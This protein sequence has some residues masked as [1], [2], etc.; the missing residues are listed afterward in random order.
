MES[1]FIQYIGNK[2][3]KPDNVA[4]SNL[5]WKGHG[6][7]LEVSSVH[8]T[9]LLQH[10]TIWRDVTDQMKDGQAPSPS[11]N[12]AGVQFQG[13]RGEQILQAIKMMDET[14]S[15]HFDENGNPSIAV[16]ESTLQYEITP[17]E[18]GLVVQDLR[19]ARDEN[20]GR[21]EPEA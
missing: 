3:E 14:N 8:A 17:D 7:T 6:D 10:P 19:K 16:V 4:P 18:L 20:S 13:G 1:K 2:P 9:I 5:V 11:A 12:A 21:V 15:E